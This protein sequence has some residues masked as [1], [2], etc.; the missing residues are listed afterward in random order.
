MI[1]ILED[2]N[3]QTTSSVAKLLAK[4]FKI[5]LKSNLIASTIL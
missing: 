1:Q 5:K 2:A 4:I 3:P